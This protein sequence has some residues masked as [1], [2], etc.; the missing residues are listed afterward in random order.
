MG[1]KKLNDGEKLARVLSY[2][3]LIDEVHSQVEKIVCPFHGDVN[4]SLKVDFGSGDWF[5]FGCQ[6]RG[7]A[8]DFV[9]EAERL[10]DPKLN[11][12]QVFMIYN[13]ILDGSAVG[14]RIN[15]KVKTKAERKKESRELYDIAYDFYHGLSKVDWKHPSSDEAREV[16]GYMRSRGFTAEDLQRVRAKV[17]YSK[18]YELVFPI[19]D[20]GKFRGWVSRTDDPEVAKYR[21]YLYNK[22]FRRAA[23]VVGEYDSKSPLFIVEGF[24]DRL[25]LLHCGIDNVVAIFG[26]KASDTQ[27]RKIKAAGIEHVIS[28]LDN[29]DCGRKGTDYLK[30]HFKVTRFCYL[31]KFKDPG[32][33]NKKSCDIMLARTMQRY[34]QD[35]TS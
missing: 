10:D 12:I 26:W 2:Y 18:P 33:F 23:T 27:I 30:K 28:A 29:D 6:R 25:K 13:D 7:K 32:D 19:M 34:R 17:T 3:G 9:K 16:L 15:F 8:L 5:C 24:M 22:G 11:D 35:E 1:K 4:P 31:K 14:G 21:K 20:N